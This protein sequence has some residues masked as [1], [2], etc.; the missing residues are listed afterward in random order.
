MPVGRNVQ[1]RIEAEP[2]HA[3]NA[4]QPVILRLPGGCCRAPDALP[5]GDTLLLDVLFG[6]LLAVVGA[7]SAGALTLSNVRGGD[8]CGGAAV[9][10]GVVFSGRLCL[11][12]VPAG[13]DP[14][15]GY[16]AR[17]RGGGVRFRFMAR[18]FSAAVTLQFRHQVIPAG[19]D[20]DQ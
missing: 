15:R 11:P 14:V 9:S 6:A 1:I 17:G 8:A 13:S 3:G 19:G 7:L 20:N 10:V 18:A 16:C 4:R 12:A 5:A 2:L